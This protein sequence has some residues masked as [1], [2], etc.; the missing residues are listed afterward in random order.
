LELLERWLLIR[1]VGHIFR[2]NFHELLISRGV[3]PIS[4]LLRCE[5]FLL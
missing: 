4:T 5:T 1:V 3:A 2:V